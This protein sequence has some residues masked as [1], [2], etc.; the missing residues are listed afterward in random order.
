[1]T[2]AVGLAL[3]WCTHTGV[4]AIQTYR[5]LTQKRSVLTRYAFALALLAGTAL[6]LITFA[7][8]GWSPRDD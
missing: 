3:L 4:G 6:A 1:M 5:H 8:T 7:I 2:S